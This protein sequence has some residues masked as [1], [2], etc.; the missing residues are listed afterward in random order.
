MAFRTIEVALVANVAP[1]RAQLARASMATRQFG[2]DVMDVST[3]TDAQSRRAIE[4]AGRMATVYGVAVAAAFGLSAK[5]AIGFEREMRNVN[6]ISRMSEAQLRSTGAAV[7]DMSR[8]VPQS[9]TTL[10]KGLYDIASSGFQGA[11]GM[12]ILKVSAVAA[13]AGL[14]DTATS[15]RAVTAVLNAYGLSAANAGDVSDVLFE[16]VNKGVVTFEELA[17]TIGDFVGSAAAARIPIDDASAAIAAMTLSGV[18]ASEAGTS[19]NRVI[20]SLI[21]PS[22]DLAVVLRQHGYESG[23]AALESLGLAGVMDMLRKAT[24]GNLDMLVK[25][26]PE[27]RATRGVLGLMANEG[28]NFTSTLESISDETERAGAAQRAFNE[29]SK[30]TAFQLELA[31]NNVVALAIATGDVLLPVI[32]GAAQFTG[33]LATG[34]SSIEG[35]ARTAVAVF[36]LTTGAVALLGGGLLLLAPRIIAVK[37][38]MADMATTSPR[39]ATGIST[40]ASWVG[41]LTPL[42][43]IATIGLGMYASQKAEAKQRTDELVDALAQELQGVTGTTDAWITKQLVVLDA[44]SAAQRLGIE[45]R[46]LMDAIKGEESALAAVRDRLHEVNTAPDRTAQQAKDYN[47]VAN[48]LLVVGEEYANARPKAEQFATAQRASESAAKGTAGAA[49]QQSAEMQRLSQML[50]VAEGSTAGLTEAQKELARVVAGFTDPLSVLSAIESEHEQA[51]K[52]SAKTTESAAK[53]EIDRRQALLGVERARQRVFDAEREYQRVLADVDYEALRQ[54]ERDLASAHGDVERAQLRVIDAQERLNNLRRPSARTVE[55]AELDLRSAVVANTRAQEAAADAQ[56][57]LD[58]LREGGADPGEIARA[59]LDLEDALIRGREAELRLADAHERL[60]N[61]RAGGTARQLREAELDLAAAQRDSAGAAASVAA[62]QREVDEMRD[63]G[64]VRALRDAELNLAEALLGVQSAQQQVAG[65]QRKGVGASDEFSAATKRAE[66]SLAQFEQ[67]LRDQIEAQRQWEQNLVTIARRG[68]SDTAAAFA[69]LGRDHAGIVS[70]MA[71]ATDEQ[72]GR[73]AELM[74]T[75]TRIGGQAHV[76]E[77]DKA[78]KIARAT[79]ELGA[80]ATVAAVAE[81]LNLG[82]AEVQRI[83]AEFGV[84]LVKSANIVLAATDAGTI[85]FNPVTGTYHAPGGVNRQAKGGIVDREAQVA[86]AGANILWAEPETGGEAYIPKRGDRR[87]ALT[88]LE[89]AANWH[90]AQVIAMRSGGVVLPAPPGFDDFGLPLSAPASATTRMEHDAVLDFLG[91]R[92]TSAGTGVAGTLGGRGLKAV[93]AYLDYRGV[94]H[95]VSSGYRPG[96]ITASGNRSLHGVLVGPGNPQAGDLV[97]ATVAGM[98]R[99]FDTL[100]EVRTQLRELFFTPAGY[101][102]KNGAAIRPPIAAANHFDHVHAAT[103]DRGGPLHPGLTL[104]YNGT[105]RDEWVSPLPASGMGG[106]G[107]VYNVRAE[108]RIEQRIAA[109][110]DAELYARVAREAIEPA[111]DAFAEELAMEIR[112]AS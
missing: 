6:S 32:R 23:Q 90:G 40:T 14:S 84:E 10:A 3:R 85:T 39:L 26:F 49:S 107:N 27:M 48:R 38:L 73:M 100:A 104:A 58:A 33:M 36:M 99:I 112:G 103:Y 17:N 95:R 78:M 41:R 88:T 98:R 52:R 57:K 46:D 2:A 42:L 66:V 106:G 86:P 13:S 20:Q 19:L 67:G 94:P 70:Q 21:D 18:S 75:K 108:L 28:R 56:E 69:A 91:G 35:P 93:T 97:A 5:A 31:K 83:A 81:K 1:Y 61:V 25:L 53:T 34:F 110:A 96:S 101:S 64:R 54:A 24:G 68:G 45:V 79:A 16:T 77:L 72:F 44:V 7:V 29:Q 50:G 82:K 8:T 37:A 11:E 109:G 55:E 30:S 76:D 102:I 62:K 22:E 12:T 111:L 47:I 105:G 87:R 15:A 65:S 80:G 63:S 9:A 71:G 4:T 60:N 59:E 43:T 92:Y 74:R 51:V 89:T